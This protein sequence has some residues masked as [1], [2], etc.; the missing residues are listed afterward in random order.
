M[1]RSKCGGEWAGDS[2]D[3]VEL[4]DLGA[5]LVELLCLNLGNIFI[6]NLS[7]LEFRRPSF[8]VITATFP[9]TFNDLTGL[10]FYQYHGGKETSRSI[11]QQQQQQQL[12]ST[13]QVGVDFDLKSNRS[14]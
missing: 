5:K 8:S 10:S 2:P 1:A 6:I 11:I 7:L 12:L 4:G 9:T 13:K 14:N 3:L